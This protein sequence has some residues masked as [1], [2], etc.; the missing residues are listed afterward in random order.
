MVNGNHFQFDYKSF[1]NF[2]KTIFKTVNRFSKLI[3]S[4]LYVRLISDC[5]NLAMISRQNLTGAGIWHVWQPEFCQRRNPTT[6]GNRRRI[7][8]MVRSQPDL[9]RSG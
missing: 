8:A 5:Q 9:D 1:F 6:Y 4:F 7:S 3:S 2:W